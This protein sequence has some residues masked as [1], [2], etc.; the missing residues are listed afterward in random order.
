M[1]AW[2]NAFIAERRHAYEAIQKEIIDVTS[3]PGYFFSC[4]L[5]PCDREEMGFDEGIVE[6]ASRYPVVLDHRKIVRDGIPMDA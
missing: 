3:Q 1:T 5:T 2:K 6:E 4:V